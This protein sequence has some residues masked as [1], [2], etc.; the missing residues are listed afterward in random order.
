MMDEHKMLSAAIESLDGQIADAVRGAAALSGGR[1][2]EI[3][4]N[5]EGRVRI[6]VFGRVIFVNVP[7][8]P[9][10][11]DRTLRRLCGNSLYSHADT[12]RDGYISTADGLRVGVCGR[13]VLEGGAIVRVCD[14]TSLC[15][16]IPIRIPGAADE[17]LPLI[18]RDGG[19]RSMLVW[20][21]PG[22]GKTTILREL[23]ARL[24]EVD[25]A[26]RCAV[27]DSRCEIAC[28]LDV[29][30]LDVLR[31]YPRAAGMEIAV[32]T[33][34]P[35]IVICDEIAGDADA[36]AVLSCAASGTAVIATAHAASRADLLRKA[37][38]RRLAEAH[39]FPSFVGLRRDADKISFDLFKENGE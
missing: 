26:L 24:C 28:G 33:M 4:L 31:G 20:S 6:V 3:R 7:C 15:I 38:L 23:A 37:P 19:V 36:D 25:R 2:Q 8:S 5:R 34:A 16:R 21:P 27:V 35:Q 22:V 1:V 13:A 12:I 29:G 30:A 32:R 9:D 11:F 10:A 39:V 18:L 17:L 14:I